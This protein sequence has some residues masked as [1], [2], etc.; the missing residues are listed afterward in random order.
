[1][2]QY[3]FFFVFKY[4]FRR[5][6]FNNFLKLKKIKNYRIIDLSGPFRYYLIS[7]ILIMLVQIFSNKFSNFI[8][9][10]CDGLPFLKKNSVNIWFGGTSLKIPK[11]YTQYKNNLPMIKN[12]IFKEKNFINLYP[13]N[14]K[15]IKFRGE[16]KIVYASALKLQ[17]SNTTLKIWK[18][19]KK[20][21]LKNLSLIDDKKFWKKNKLNQSDKKHNIYLEINNLIRL[22][23]IKEVNKKFKKD[24]LVVGTEW[25]KHINN[26][27]PNNYDSEYI[28]NL[29]NGNLC[30][31]F[32]SRWGDNPL[33]PRSIEIIEAG[34]L[35]LQSLKPDATNA[36]GD[37]KSFITF[38]SVNDL[39]KKIKYY[40]KNYNFLVSNY[41][42]F[43]Y[44]FLNKNKNYD[45][46][47]AIKNIAKK[48]S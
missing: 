13:Y 38:N 14:L 46:L 3:Y 29:Y 36:F 19:N 42:K 12:F 11:K 20:K 45:N 6:A 41:E 44:L 32:G 34:G 31:D 9:I 37:L 24:F 7:K 48:N 2:K 10:S 30:L 43:S 40:K 15:K 25:K 17:T 1:M 21:I 4:R 23:V 35:L 5:A 16:F 33:Y 47:T 8:L 18:N 22:N 28:R 39:L 27:I 26:S